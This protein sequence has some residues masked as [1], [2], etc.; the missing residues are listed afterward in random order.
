MSDLLQQALLT[1]IAQHRPKQ[2]LWL[3]QPS[4]DLQAWLSKALPDCHLHCHPE[5]PPA[6]RFD[7]CVIDGPLE[8]LSKSAGQALIGQVRNLY[9]SQLLIALRPAAQQWL[10]TDLYAHAVVLDERFND[11]AQPAWL[12]SYNLLHYK[13]AP[14]WLNARF[15]ANPEMFDKFR[16]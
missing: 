6:Q 13:P 9:S 16:W 2:L 10:E 4:A 14:D 8:Q 1:R 7:L 11:C 3:G 5:L 15:W 12:A